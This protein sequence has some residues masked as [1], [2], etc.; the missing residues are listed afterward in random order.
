VGAALNVR[1]NLP[2]ITEVQA[3]KRFAKSQETHLRR[4]HELAEQVRSAVD[5]VLTEATP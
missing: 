5:G 2:S 4:A 3:A 1:I